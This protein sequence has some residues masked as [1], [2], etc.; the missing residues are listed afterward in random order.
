MSQIF[1]VDLQKRINAFSQLGGYFRRFGGSDAKTEKIS[2]NKYFDRL[3]NVVEDSYLHNG[4]FIEKNVRNML[5]SLGE[6]LERDS[7]ENWVSEYFNKLNIEHQPKTVAVIMAG[8]VPAVGF[9]DFLSVLI[10]GNRILAKLSSDDNRLLPAIANL[11]ISIEPEFDSFISFTEGKLKDFD[12]IIATGSGNTSRYFEY[13]FGKYNNIIRS[14]RNG[15]AV[16]RGNETDS[17]FEFLAQDIF[18]YFGLGCRNVSKLFVP[19]GYDFVPMLNIFSKNEEIS[20]HHKYFNN[21]EYNKAI[22]LVNSR[23]HYDTGNVLLVE[24]VA[25]A[26]PV[27]VINYEYYSSIDDLNRKLIFEK[28]SIQCI[29]TGSDKINNSISFGQSQQPQLWDYADGIDTVE[30]LLG[31]D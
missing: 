2:E 22:Y 17:D 18:M 9:H 8:N 27:S 20:N 13:Y 30:F 24:D 7:L 23:S 10:S 25:Y 11:L 28:K 12:S 19:E 6:S 26:S 5:F 21:Y 4:W 1:S 3:A 15:V 31:S 16:L 14:N 29:V